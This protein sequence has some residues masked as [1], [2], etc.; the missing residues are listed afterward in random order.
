MYKSVRISQ[1]AY[2]VIEE[3]A[4]RNRRSIVATI[5]IMVENEIKR[6]TEKLYLDS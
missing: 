4:K 3:L 1:E 5:D 6:E 2:D